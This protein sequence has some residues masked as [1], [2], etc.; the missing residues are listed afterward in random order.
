MSLIEK[1]N[2]WDREGILE[3][4]HSYDLMHED[5]K[6]LF[7]A[8]TE[9]Y[10]FIREDSNNRFSDL[11]VKYTSIDIEN[12]NATKSVSIKVSVCPRQSGG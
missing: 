1:Y 6:K 3:Y 7:N 5:N 4:R 10:T 9:A 12:S 2:S 11:T 8:D